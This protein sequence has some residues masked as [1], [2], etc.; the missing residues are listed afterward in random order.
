[1]TNPI[2]Y[3]PGDEVRLLRPSSYKGRIGRYVEPADDHTQV[4][5]AMGKTPNS[6]LPTM[7][8]YNNQGTFPRRLLPLTAIEPAK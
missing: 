6:P 4:W 7:G 1:M 3:E 2:T 5:I 8:N